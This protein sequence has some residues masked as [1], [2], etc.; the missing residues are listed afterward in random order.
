MSTPSPNSAINNLTNF[1]G[2]SSY[3]VQLIL[4]VGI[5]IMIFISVGYLINKKRRK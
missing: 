4:V 1:L 3:S 2:V 5:F